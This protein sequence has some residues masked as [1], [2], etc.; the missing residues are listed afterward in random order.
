ML[1]KQTLTF[2]RQLKRH[3]EREWF[4]AHREQYLAAKADVEALV[5]RILE[6]L[7]AKDPAFASL[8]LKDCM[9]RI[10]RDTRF[11]QDKTPYKTHFGAGINRGGKKVHAPGYY[12]HLEPGGL[13]YCGG[14]LWRPE[15]PLLKKVRQEIDYNADEYR[16]IL[17]SRNFRRRFGGLE[18]GDALQRAPQGYTED[19]PAIAYLKM[20]SFV[21]GTGLTDE[22]LLARDLDKR[23]LRIFADLSP[24]IGFL[25]RALD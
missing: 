17:E 1:Q 5:T 12:L 22:Q 13:S 25:Q 6:G 4:E 10:Y 19:N 20:R 18:E 3:N 7:A 14:G 21:A 15:A 9:F 24:F 8:R 23:V 2:L 16:A 11:S